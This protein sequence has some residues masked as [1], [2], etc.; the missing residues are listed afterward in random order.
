MNP[1]PIVKQYQTLPP[2][3]KSTPLLWALVI[4]IPL[5]I[6][7]IISIFF[8]TQFNPML[9]FEKGTNPQE[10]I[11]YTSGQFLVTTRPLIT[12]EEFYNNITKSKEKKGPESNYSIK[13]PKLEYQYDFYNKKKTYFDICKQKKVKINFT[14]PKESKFNFNYANKTF[15]YEI[16][17]YEDLYTFTDNLK[18]Q[19]CYFAS[20]EYAKGYLLDPY[21]SKFMESVAQDFKELKNNGYTYNQ[22]LEIATLFVQSIKYGTDETESNRYAYETFYEEE[23]NC[24]D[25][26]IILAEILKQL[27]FTTYIILGQSKE[28]HALVGVV[29]D[30]GN[31]KYENQEICFIETTIFTPISSEVNISIEKFVEV[32]SGN[33]IYNEANYGRKLTNKFKTSEQEIKKIEIQLESFNPQSEKLQKEMCKT[34]CVVCNG[35]LV[36]FETS[37]QSI[38]SCYD[39]NEYNKLG[40]E[41]EDI[42]LTHNNLIREWYNIYYNLEQ[43]MF[44]NIEIVKRI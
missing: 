5:L 31:V 27:N 21:N 2:Q 11:T 32:S 43:S 28:Y 20:N 8:L 15:T 13:S 10:I 1:T 24:L 41:Y 34:D 35:E 19:S 3:K 6:T 40:R 14:N 25:K 23:G 42:I 7:L 22:I 33:K 4:L 29:C 9:I 36:D 44:E 39:A 12:S 37:S 30:K 16:N 18:S 38:T 26:S 17:L